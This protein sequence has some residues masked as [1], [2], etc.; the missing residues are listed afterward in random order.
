MVFSRAQQS[1][2]RVS[3]REF[4]TAS[5]IDQEFRNRAYYTDSY[6]TWLT[7]LNAT[8]VEL[9]KAI[10]AHR[11]TWMKRVIAARNWLAAR[12]GLDAPTVAE[13]MSPSRDEVHAVDG[14]IGGWH[15]FVLTDHELIAGRDNKH[16]D[17]R[18][19]IMRETGAE[20]SNGVVSTV[21][22]VHNVFGKIY[23][24]FVLPFHR[25]GLRWLIS[26]ASANG[27]L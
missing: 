27:R 20:I 5:L 26:S 8:P 6:A 11:P 23:L 18:V 13:T 14:R 2:D 24:F 9:F 12:L 15:I 3:E 4:P 16:L 10:F 17:F 19:S 25:R 1:D 21:C 22:V 7:R